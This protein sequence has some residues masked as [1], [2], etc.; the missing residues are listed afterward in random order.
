[1]AK[2]LTRL[3]NASDMLGKSDFLLGA[4][5]SV[6]DAYLFTVLTWSKHFAI[7]LNQWPAIA[8]FFERVGARPAVKAALEAEAAAKKAT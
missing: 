6:A 1:M 3:G 8:K 5:F 7:D 4:Q 2:L